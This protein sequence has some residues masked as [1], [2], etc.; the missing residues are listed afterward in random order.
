VRPVQSP[1]LSAFEMSQTNIF[2]NDKKEACLADF[3]IARALECS[4][5]TTIGKGSYRWMARELVDDDSAHFNPRPTLA[6]DVWAFAMCG[7]EVQ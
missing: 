7:L 5:F 1:F 3:G 2:V 6:T 4:G